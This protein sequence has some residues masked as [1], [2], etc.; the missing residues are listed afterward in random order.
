[1][2]VVEHFDLV[3]GPQS[4]ECERVE[5]ILQ[6]LADVGVRIRDAE[7]VSWPALEQAIS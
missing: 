1:M 3:L 5:V 6:N 4:S 2:E 7:F